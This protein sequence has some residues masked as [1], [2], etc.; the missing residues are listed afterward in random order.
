VRRIANGLM[1]LGL[2]VGVID[3]GAIFFH[4]GLAGVP[5]LV[6]VALAKLAFIGALGLLGGGAVVGRLARRQDVD[7]ISSG[8]TAGDEPGKGTT[9][10]ETPRSHSTH[11]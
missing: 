8:D 9:D 5:W 4:L 10:V 1:G 6:N 2:A 11:Q 7:R 3:A